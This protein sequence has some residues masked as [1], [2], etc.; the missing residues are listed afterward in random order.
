[1]AFLVIPTEAKQSA[2][3]RVVSQWRPYSP[4]TRRVLARILAFIESGSLRAFSS[5][6]TIAISQSGLPTID[7]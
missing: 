6:V 3:M 5:G 2:V 1:M 4:K 7:G